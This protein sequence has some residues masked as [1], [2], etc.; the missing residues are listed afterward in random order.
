MVLVQFSRLENSFGLLTESSGTVRGSRVRPALQTISHGAQRMLPELARKLTFFMPWQAHVLVNAVLLSKGDEL[1]LF[2]ALVL[3]QRA[4]EIC[5]QRW[6][7]RSGLSI[8]NT[9]MQ[10]DALTRPKLADQ[11]KRNEENEAGREKEGE[12]RKKE[13]ERRRRVKHFASH[14]DPRG[15]CDGRAEDRVMVMA[16]CRRQAA[17][18]FAL[19]WEPHW[20]HLRREERREETREKR[21][22][23]REKK[24]RDEGRGKR[25]EKRE[26]REERRGKREEGIEKREERREK[27]EEGRGKREEGREKRAQ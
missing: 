1:A 23:R 11:A 2:C 3:R 4:G 10:C 9:V 16:W 26:K 21:E 5:T 14:A 8:R 20:P 24:K 6:H 25:E 13:G 7:E 27:R 22:E 17:Q 15:A 12:G 19:S 18:A